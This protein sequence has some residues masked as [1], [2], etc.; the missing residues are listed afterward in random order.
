MSNMNALQPDTELCPAVAQHEDW[1]Q[2]MPCVDELQGGEDF[3]C[4]EWTKGTA[5]WMC[6]GWDRNDC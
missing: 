2:A 4:A 1:Y 6:A 3:T 5:G